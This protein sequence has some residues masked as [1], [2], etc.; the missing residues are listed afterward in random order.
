MNSKWFLGTR[1]AIQEL[2]ILAKTIYPAS[3]K[4][5]IEYARSFIG[6]CIFVGFPL[7]V[8][9]AEPLIVTV[10]WPKC[11]KLPTE[12][13]NRPDFSWAEIST[14]D[15]ATD[16]HITLG[17]RLWKYSLLI[18][19]TCALT[20]LIVTSLEIARRLNLRNVWWIVIAVA[21][22]GLGAAIHFGLG[23]G[24]PSTLPLIEVIKKNH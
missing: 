11:L 10:L 20:A 7:L 24:E 4:Q 3:G 2:V 21:F 17:F 16:A 1:Q 22:I 15:S 13:T 19:S 23:F 8:C 18:Y 14:V 6:R 9:I 12:F 5:M